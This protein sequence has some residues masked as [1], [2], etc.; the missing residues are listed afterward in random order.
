MLS[1]DTSTKHVCY[2]IIKYNLQLPQ[3]GRNAQLY[4]IFPHVVAVGNSRVVH[5]T[6]AMGRCLRQL[7]RESA[8]DNHNLIYFVS[9]LLPRDLAYDHCHQGPTHMNS[10][11]G[12]QMGVSE[13]LHFPSPKNVESPPP[14]NPTSHLLFGQPPTPQYISQRGRPRL[15]TQSTIQ[16]CNRKIQ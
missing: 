10:V 12:Q 16:G 5:P 8:W 14:T 2:I 7:S 9:S 11:L 1:V 4:P 6:V 3:M 15:V 13:G